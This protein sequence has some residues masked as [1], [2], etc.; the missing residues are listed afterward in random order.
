MLRHDYVMTSRYHIKKTNNIF[1]LND[2][3]NHG[4][5]KRINFLVH[6]QAEIG[7]SGLVTSWHDV[8]TS[9]YHTNEKLI[10]YLNSLTQKNMETKKE[11][12]F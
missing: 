10:A 11:S 3:K 7:E 4:N 9:R 12:T 8:M 1:E 2:P 5:N 6:L